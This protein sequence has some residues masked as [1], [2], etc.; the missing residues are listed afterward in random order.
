M[1]VTNEQRG[2]PGKKGLSP[3]AWIAI[4]CAGVLVL[5]GIA[6][7][8]GG[9]FIF[10][11]ARDVVQEME[12][13]PVLATA[14]LIDA[15]NP[16]I[17]L[18]ETDQENRTVTFRNSETGEEFT[19][20]YQDIEEGK[21]SFSSDEGSVT[22]DVDAQEGQEGRLT[23][24]TDEGTAMLGGGVSLERFPD[25][26]PVY[27]GTSPQGTFFTESPEADMGAYVVQT[28]DDLETVFDYYATEL[29]KAGLAVVQRTTTPSGI[30]LIANSPESVRT[31]SV[32]GSLEAGE[33]KAMVNFTEKK[34]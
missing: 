8:L 4:G 24:T 21:F 17:E 15:T 9:L 27:P 20:G 12:E 30:V 6:T 32:T 28:A 16:D 33:V 7:F 23:V 13:D 10:N 3:W 22:Y 11:K 18:V 34:E 25:W 14:K 31:V 29:E 2:V 19:F 5:V 26:L 1:A